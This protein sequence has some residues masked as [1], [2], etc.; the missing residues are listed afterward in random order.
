MQFRPPPPPQV[1]DVRPVERPPPV[2]REC[3]LRTAGHRCLWHVGGTADEK[4]DAPTWRRRL[5]GRLE[6]RPVLV[7]RR[8]V[9]KSSQG[10]RQPGGQSHTWPSLSGG[11]IAAS[12]LSGLIPCSGGDRWCPLR[13]STCRFR[14]PLAESRPIVDAS[15]ALLLDTRAA[16]IGRQATADRCPVEPGG[17]RQ[18]LCDVAGWSKLPLAACL[19]LVAT[20]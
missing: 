17:A 1:R 11:P 4:E 5:P 18:S 19:R 7:I 9:G 8:L 2:D 13:S 14:V 15:G 16:S 20:G 6:V 12:R 10:S 3:P